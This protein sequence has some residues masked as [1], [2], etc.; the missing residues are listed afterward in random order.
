MLAVG[1]EVA[2]IQG[3]SFAQTTIRHLDA[4]TDIKTKEE[5][6]REAHVCFNCHKSFGGPKRL[7]RHEC[8]VKTETILPLVVSNDSLTPIVLSDDE[9]EEDQV[10]S[11]EIEEDEEF[12]DYGDFE[13][14]DKIDIIEGDNDDDEDITEDSDI[15]NPEDFEQSGDSNISHGGIRIFGP[16]TWSTIVPEQVD[17]IP[18]DIDG[19]RV[20]NVRGKTREELLH[21][22]KDGRPWK[23]DSSTKWHSYRSLVRYRDCNG[24][25]VCPREECELRIENGT[26]N[27]LKFDNNKV[28]SSFSS[29]S[30][31]LSLC[32]F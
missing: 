3:C 19:K 7:A 27:R 26:P 20:Y 15:N 2:V 30:L 18:Y 12:S 4:V 11:I 22:C 5:P 31:N 17:S 29:L 16:R 24:S 14:E 25:L 1:P 32:A 28:T 10:Y 9:V 8:I 6:K 13:F 23:K 21:R